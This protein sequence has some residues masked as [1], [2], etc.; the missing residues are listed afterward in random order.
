MRVPAHQ[1]EVD[2]GRGGGDA[3]A[4]PS[5]DRGLAG[6]EPASGEGL[7][8]LVEMC[9][10]AYRDVEGLPAIIM[11]AVQAW[12]GSIDQDDDITLIVLG[13]A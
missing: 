13:V 11:A 3:V 7:A 1:R 9:A 4:A 6:A 5:D 8:R 2:D 12:A 10:A